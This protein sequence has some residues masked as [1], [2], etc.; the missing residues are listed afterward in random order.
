M[1]GV[2]KIREFL[3][4][5]GGLLFLVVSVSAGFFPLLAV[6]RL[7][8]RDEGFYV[9]AA[10]L[11][12]EGELPYLDFF[13]PQMPLLPYLYALPIMAVGESWEV[14]RI[15]T[16]GAG[17]ALAVL[18]Y[19]FLRSSGVVWI[20]ALTAW[21]WFLTSH[22]TIGWFTVIQTY[23][24][25]TLFLFLAVWLAGSGR[26][27]PLSGLLFSAAVQIR[28][29]FAA[30]APLFLRKTRSELI[31]FSLGFSALLAVSLF[32]FV[33]DPS[34]FLYNN[35]GYHF[36]RSGASLSEGMEHRWLILK[37]LIGFHDSQKFDSFQTP[38]L[39]VGLLA[40]F[41]YAKGMPA[42]VRSMRNAAGLLVLVSFLPDPVYLQYFCTVIPFALVVTFERISFLWI[43][44]G[45]VVGRIFI[46]A[47]MIAASWIYAKDVVREIGRYTSTGQGVIGIGGPG[48]AEDW[49][50]E[51][52]ADVRIM[53]KEELSDTEMVY[54][55]W[56]GYLFGTSF[57]PVL[58]SENHFARL[59]AETLSPD[60]ERRFH[61]LSEAGVLKRIQECRLPAVLGWRRALRGELRSTLRA[62]ECYELTA[63]SGDVELYQRV[64]RE[65]GK[66]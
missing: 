33:L 44:C 39:V 53:L 61:I 41:L 65:E 14:L 10:R 6:D 24:F 66:E 5:E 47:A 25:S 46:A 11:V 9:L 60:Q 49:S 54:A 59:A 37:I 26:C 19:L 64:Q 3:K 29:F 2:K 58:G 13:Y 4:R 50:L 1:F 31:S 43:R 36:S 56:P 34:A 57:E 48:R 22:L 35:L 23:S 42:P 32:L 12:L 45:S 7:I 15:I 18:L 27:T 20:A 63:R 30:L 28:L 51:R 21:L 40:G 52:L 8:S 55:E 17:A 38:F 62:S 16:G